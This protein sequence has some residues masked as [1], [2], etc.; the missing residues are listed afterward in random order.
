MNRVFASKAGA[1]L[2]AA[3]ISASLLTGCVVAPARGGY[4][5]GV[6]LDIDVAPP[7]DR[8]YVAAPR[9]GYVYA[10]GYWRWSGRE[11]VWTEGHYM[12]ERRGYHWAPDHWEQRGGHYHLER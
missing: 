1:G 7:P 10:P 2:V 12:R 6:G 3:A 8:V 4:Y 11:H 9:G 5:G